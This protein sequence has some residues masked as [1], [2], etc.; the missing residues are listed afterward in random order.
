MSLKFIGF[1]FRN[2]AF[3]GPG[4]R[5]VLATVIRELQRMITPDLELQAAI[6]AYRDHR[7]RDAHERRIIG[8]L[9]QLIVHRV[10]QTGQISYSGW[11]WDEHKIDA[12]SDP[13]TYVRSQ[14]Y[15][16]DAIAQ[17]FKP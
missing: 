3:D 1:K 14:R 17:E 2:P 8:D 10:N 12:R 6:R 9:D 4:D 11:L 13:E 16:L 7:C 15:W 5:R